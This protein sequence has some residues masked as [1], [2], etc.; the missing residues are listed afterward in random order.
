[1]RGLVH[2][3][4]AFAFRGQALIGLGLVAWFISSVPGAIARDSYIVGP[5]TVTVFAGVTA[6]ASI[7]PYLTPHWVGR[8]TRVGQLAPLLLTHTVLPLLYLF[9]AMSAAIIANIAEPVAQYLT[10]AISLLLIAASL[11]CWALGIVLCVWSVHPTPQVSI[12]IDNAPYVARVPYVSQPE[13]DITTV[14]PSQ[15][16]AS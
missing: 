14:Q 8:P 7:W 15:Q 6:L 11:V 13:T 5:L 16:K 10:V 1:M 9:V 12:V 3:L 4:Y 2:T